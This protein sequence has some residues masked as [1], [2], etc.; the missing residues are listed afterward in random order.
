M[1][2]DELTATQDDAAFAC[3]SLRIDDTVAEIA[4][5]H[6]PLNLVTQRLLRDHN[7]ALRAVASA[8]GI[9]CVVLHGGTA[10]AFCAGAPSNLG[11]LPTAF[12][13]WVCP[14]SN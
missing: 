1:S 10:R 12:R 8:P 9:R 4:L 6:G 5:D 7:G 2:T 14:A 3:V 11:V 13:G